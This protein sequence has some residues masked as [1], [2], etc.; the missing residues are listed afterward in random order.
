MDLLARIRRELAE[1]ADFWGGQIPG[2]LGR[3][4]R[5]RYYRKRL[6]RLGVGASLEVG[7]QI[8]GPQ[9][10]SV[11]EQF[12]CMRDCF[13]AAGD[14]RIE[15]G[16]RVR[17]NTNVHMNACIRGRIVLGNDVLVGPNVVMRTSDHVTTALDRP[18][19][20]Q[21]H[22]SG[23]IIVED[24]VWL[25]GNVSLVGGVHVGRGAVVAAGAVVIHDVE[26]YTIVGGVPARFIKKRGE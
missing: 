24:D 21:G 20:Q 3:R 9:N 5:F 11:G 22:I 23:E 15:I 12:S 18:I 2:T 10:V 26:P 1:H 7:L 13:L 19:T 25:G 6:K 4:F 16:D 17:F 14:G 8:I